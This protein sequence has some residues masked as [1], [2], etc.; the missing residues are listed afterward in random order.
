MMLPS[1]QSATGWDGMGWAFSICSAAAKTCQRAHPGWTVALCRLIP[2]SAENSVALRRKLP[3]TSE[4]LDLLE[5]CRCSAR[6]AGP[7]RPGASSQTETS[8]RPHLRARSEPGGGR[9][10]RRGRSGRAA[11]HADTAAA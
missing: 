7:C 9:A 6:E 8:C 5:G 1:T 10:R 2:A 4:C 3:E 11:R